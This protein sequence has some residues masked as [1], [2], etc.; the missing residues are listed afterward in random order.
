MLVL[1]VME[2]FHVFIRKDETIGNYYTY[3]RVAY[4]AGITFS[5]IVIPQLCGCCTR[6]NLGLIAKAG[7]GRV[8][9]ICLSMTGPSESRSEEVCMSMLAI[10]KSL[11]EHYIN[12][13]TSEGIHWPSQ[14]QDV[15]PTSQFLLPL[16]PSG[17]CTLTLKQP[18]YIPIRHIWHSFSA[19][20]VRLKV[21]R[22]K[23][24]SVFWIFFNREKNRERLT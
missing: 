11:L 21:S 18:Y 22:V 3:N 15:P 9:N 2:I 4:Y 8:K 17:F 6:L 10:A 14:Y 20:I 24:M 23:I 7:F 5:V 1:N 12:R 16:L 19:P 13:L